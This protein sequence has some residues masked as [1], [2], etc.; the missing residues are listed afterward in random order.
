[1]GFFCKLALVKVFSGVNEPEENHLPHGH[2]SGVW[3]LQVFLAI[4][5]RSTAVVRVVNAGSLLKGCTA[6]H[7]PASSLSLAS[8]PALD[9]GQTNW[10]LG[11]DSV[12]PSAPSAS[13]VSRRH[14]RAAVMHTQL[15][16]QTQLRAAGDTGTLQPLLPFCTSTWV[17]P[18]W[19]KDS[20]YSWL[21]LWLPVFGCTGRRTA[22]R[23][24]HSRTIHGTSLISQR[25]QFRNVPG[26]I[27]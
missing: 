11:K 26:S 27:Q 18:S 21:M 22:S 9:L 10:C 12:R 4:V 25:N 6:G 16:S 7:S 3:F 2:V 5:C 8:R 20:E 17:S 1:M 24:A 23:T 13:A 15:H 14:F 19:E